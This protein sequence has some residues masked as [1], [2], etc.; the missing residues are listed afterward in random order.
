MDAKVDYQTALVSKSENWFEFSVQTMTTIPKGGRLVIQGD[1]YAQ[2][3]EFADPCTDD[4]YIDR[5]LSD[6][7]VTCRFQIVEEDLQNFANFCKLLA[8]SF[9]AVSKGSF[10]RKYAFD[11]IFQALQDLHI[12][13]LLQSQ[14]F[15]KKSVSK[16]SNFREN[17]AT[18][19]ILQ[20]CKIC[21]I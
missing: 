4:I 20:G 17:S 9:S 11:S 5:T 8:G 7:D 14:N 10:A 15:S 19:N 6:I 21:K 3:F 1:K 18:L 2:G 12:I 16:I 13:S